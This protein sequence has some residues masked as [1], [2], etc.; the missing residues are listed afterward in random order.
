MI[1]GNYMYVILFILWYPQNVTSQII[2]EGAQ[3]WIR[4]GVALEL[5]WFQLGFNL[6]FTWFGSELGHS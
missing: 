4:F 2:R 3:V 6:V 1:F 5:L